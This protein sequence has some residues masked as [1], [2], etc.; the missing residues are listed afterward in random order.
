MVVIFLPKKKLLH[1]FN[2]WTKALSKLLDPIIGGPCSWLLLT[3][4]LQVSQF[5]KTVTLSMDWHGGTLVLL[6]LKTAG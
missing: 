5:L 4:E 3:Q 6:Q 2:P 1:L